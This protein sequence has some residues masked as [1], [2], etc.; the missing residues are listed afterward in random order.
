MDPTERC[1][2]CDAIYDAIHEQFK[3]DVL[4]ASKRSTPDYCVGFLDLDEI[5]PLYPVDVLTINHTIR[6]IETEGRLC[7]VVFGTERHGMRL[8]ILH[9]STTTEPKAVETPPTTTWQRGEPRSCLCNES[10]I[11]NAVSKVAGGRVVYNATPETNLGKITCTDVRSHPMFDIT[12]WIQ[13]LTEMSKYSIRGVWCYFN[14]SASD[15][16]F[17]VEVV[18]GLKVLE[19]E[20]KIDSVDLQRKKKPLGFWEWCWLLMFM[21]TLYATINRLWNL[22]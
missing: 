6:S 2:C 8:G 19:Q 22:L 15:H 18:T 20:N 1:T 5:S 10:V 12:A 3:M 16:S 21:I 9:E 4:R 13:E 7:L 11:A 14:S 17:A